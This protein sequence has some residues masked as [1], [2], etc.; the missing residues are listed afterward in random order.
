MTLSR[1][2]QTQPELSGAVRLTWLKTKPQPQST[3][4]AP[5]PKK[6]KKNETQG[7]GNHIEFVSHRELAASL[8]FSLIYFLE[9][10]H[11][12]IE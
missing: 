4:I 6:I 2:L 7:K 10:I 12:L 9:N 8:V 3:P 5:P 1:K 11:W